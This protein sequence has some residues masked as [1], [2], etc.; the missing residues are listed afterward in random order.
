M[1][2][3]P[4]FFILL[5][6]WVAFFHFLGNPTFGYTKTPSL[7]A[8]LNYAYHNSVDDEHG[9]LVPLVVL[10]LLYV[11]RKEL[12]TLP[13]GQWW[14]ALTLV[15]TGL[16][17]HVFGYRVQQTRVS[18]LAFFVG[19]YG[20][21]GLVWGPRWLKASFFPFFLFVFCVPIATM[22]EKITF[23]LRILATKTTVGLA[24]M[25]L[26]IDVVQNGTNI[27]EPSGRY[28]YEVAAAC[29]GLR[30]LTAIFALATIYG[31][32][33]FRKNWQRLVII[34]SAFPLAVIGNVV[35][36]TTIIVA[37]ETFGQ[38]AGNYVHESF[39]FS[40]LPYVP[41]IAGLIF[42]GHWLGNRT[43]HPIGVLEAKP[44]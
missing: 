23:P 11:K 37:A 28:Q 42:L 3:K 35:R 19:L 24:Q 7:F 31:F 27:W 1:P 41:P 4:L 2:D 32:L 34:V 14:P 6:A 39:W 25:V 20:L 38:S 36:L 43:T 15:V 30:S 13:K 18:V 33:E 5:A 8:W 44:V 17:L 16:V 29:S 21:T 9:F 26:G 12:V 40:L 22:S 10:A